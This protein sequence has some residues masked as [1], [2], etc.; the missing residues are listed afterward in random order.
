MVQIIHHWLIYWTIRFC[1]LIIRLQ[2]YVC[3]AP[4]FVQVRSLGAE[5]DRAYGGGPLESNFFRASP[6]LGVDIDLTDILLPSQY[7]SMLDWFAVDLE[8]EHSAM[9][10]RILQEHSE[11][12][13]YAIHRVS[14]LSLYFIKWW[15]DVRC[16]IWL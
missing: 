5:S 14:L 9:D 11:Y 12:V 4:A 16:W 3:L 15:K 6:S 2:I 10:G 7:T 13:V 1:F 8:G